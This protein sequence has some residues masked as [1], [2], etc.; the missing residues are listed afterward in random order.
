MLCIRTQVPFPHDC[1][2]FIDVPASPFSR[3]HADAPI[4]MSETMI[5]TGTVTDVRIKSAEL[6]A[7]YQNIISASAGGSEPSG[8][9][10]RGFAQDAPA[11]I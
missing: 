10:P 8:P 9:D 7:M 11:G 1:H 5:I 6:C 2:F 3:N 4:R